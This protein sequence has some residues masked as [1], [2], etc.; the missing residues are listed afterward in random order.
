[1]NNLLEGLTEE[2]RIATLKILE[3]LNSKGTSDYLNNLYKQDYEEIPV[4]I[5]RFLE[6]EYYVGKSTNH[7]TLIYPYWREHLRDIFED[8]NRYQEIAFTGS[9][10]TGK[11]TAACYGMVYLLYRTMCLKDPQA[12]YK[13][14]KGSTIVFA[15]FNNTLDL[16]S[17]VGYQ[18]VQSIIQESPWF[19]ERGTVI[20]TRN[21]EYVPE[22]LIRFRVGSTASHALGTNI[23]CLVGDTE[24][25][26]SKGLKKLEDLLEE[27]IQVYSVNSE[28]N[29][30]LSDDCEVIQNGKTDTLYCIELED[31]KIIKCTANHKFLLSN[32]KYKTAEELNVDDDL[33]EVVYFE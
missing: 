12:Y 18:T 14:A 26:T 4:S 20:G 33:C 5:D 2:E 3:E 8:P 28:G 24:I 21:L 30:E 31:G 16:S 1:M 23:Q 6:D 11:S 29:I 22:K 27:S 19:L 9:I 7:G 10:G 32:G 15:F 25:I 17:S 13:L